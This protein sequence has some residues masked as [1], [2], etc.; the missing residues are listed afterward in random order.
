MLDCFKR[1]YHKP[2]REYG[3][4]GE[5][6]QFKPS[7]GIIVPH[8]EK[9]GGADTPDGKWNE[10]K[11]GLHMAKSIDRP[12]ATRDNGG[13]LAAA[14]SLKEQGCNCSLEPHKNAYNS[15]ANGYEI[16]ILKGDSLS[17]QYAELFLDA[18]AQKYPAR[19]NRGVKEMTKGGRGYR[20]LIDA[21]RGGMEV[22]L[23][24]EM[25]FIDNNS[26]WLPPHVMANFWSN[27]L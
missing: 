25:F 21:K 19:R 15:R 14:R 20:N 13:V 22:A 9:A 8:T 10:Y 24:S 4:H 3:S 17:K 11:Y 27:N 18:F 5:G 1:N 26:D 23:L 2:S 16:L 7:W 6:E 12:H